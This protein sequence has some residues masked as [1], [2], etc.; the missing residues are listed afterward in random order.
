MKFGVQD[1]IWVGVGRIGLENLNRK[2]QEE[3]GELGEVSV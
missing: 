3:R 1:I 2:K